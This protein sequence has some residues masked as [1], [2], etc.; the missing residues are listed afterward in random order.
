M[1]KKK[2]ILI[3]T[4]WFP[5]AFKAGG[6]I[7]SI[8][9]ITVLLNNTFDIYV[10]TST[11]DMDTSIE[12]Q[13][14]ITSKFVE[15]GGVNICYLKPAELVISR[16]NKVIEEVK[17]D[18]ILINGLFKKF[19]A[20][21]LFKYLL[22]QNSNY[23]LVIS[24]RGMLRKS[25]ISS[26]F[27][28]KQ[29]YLFALKY[30]GVSRKALFHCTTSQEA[31]EVL[32][33]FGKTSKI[34]IISNIPYKSEFTL[35]HSK[36]TVLKLVFA[37]RI[38]PIK[39]LDY[40]INLLLHTKL[41]IEFTIIGEPEDMT[42]WNDCKMLLNKL[43]SL[44]KIRIVGGMTHNDLMKE[45]TKHDVYILPTKG[46]N[47]GHAIY[48]AMSAGLPVIISDQ[49]PWKNLVSHKVG[50]DISLVNSAQFLEAIEYFACC[51]RE[52]LRVWSNNARD[53]SEE[54]YLSQDFKK[55]YIN[56]LSST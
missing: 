31:N 25:A 49:T 23:K 10:I 24:V 45:L 34:S 12:S 47:F 30:A 14:N 56:L 16:I 11:T 41:A 17:P 28:K 5:P 2:Q 20:I 43:G 26:N 3:L 51:S 18:T 6:P 8:Y 36:E 38:H 48:E 27:F 52:E 1:T 33:V 19:F 7:Q 21:F 4:D 42:Y 29:V 22:C 35:S 53:Y 9:N 40:I 55:S 50:F 15:V 54:F 39:N 32:N 44:I 13:I 37:S 46:E